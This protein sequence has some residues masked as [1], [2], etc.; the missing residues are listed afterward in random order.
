MMYID[1]NTISKIC[2]FQKN[3]FMP[4]GGA[5]YNLFLYK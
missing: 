2:S 1:E 4:T 5:V 3:I